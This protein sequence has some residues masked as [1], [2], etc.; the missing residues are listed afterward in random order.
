M[1]ALSNSTDKSIRA[2][3]A[4]SVSLIA[5]LD[6]PRKWTDL[7]DVRCLSSFAPRLSPTLIPSLSNSLHPYPLLNTTSIL[8]FSKPL[9]PSSVN[10]AHTSAQ[11]SSLQRL[12]LSS[13]L[14][15]PPSCNSLDKQLTCFSRLPRLL[16]RL[17]HCWRS[18]WSHSSISFTTLLAK[19]CPR[20]L[21]MH[22]TISL[23]PTEDG[24]IFFCPGIRNH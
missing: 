10:G 8:A 19:I 13:K 24:S 9:T 11:T 7:I 6:F 12:I 1:L 14:S 3:V 15:S 21:R 2:Q 4:E 17:I 20:I 23:R 16:H 22:M 18:V 5:E